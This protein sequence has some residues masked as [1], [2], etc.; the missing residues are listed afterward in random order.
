MINFY[1]TWERMG[2]IVIYIG[3]YEDD[4]FWQ[5]PAYEMPDDYSPATRE[6]YYSAKN[7]GG[8]PITTPPY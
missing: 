3:L 7:A 5:Y 6:W 8:A 4:L 1:E 2:I